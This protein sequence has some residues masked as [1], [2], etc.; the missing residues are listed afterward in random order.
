MSRRDLSLSLLTLVV[1]AALVLGA[2]AV[3]CAR[4]EE[5]QVTLEVREARLEDALQLLFRG[6]DSSY[7]LAPGNY[8]TVTA[9]LRDLPFERALTAILEPRGL[10]YRRE[11]RVYH[12]QPR[13]AEAAAPDPAPQ[14]TR[15]APAGPDQKYYWIGEGGRYQL[16]AL[17]S[18]Q[19]ASW[20]GGREIFMSPVPVAVDTPSI[21]GAT[22]GRAS[23]ASAVPSLGTGVGFGSVPGTGISS[24]VGGFASGLGATGGLSSGS[25]TGRLS[26]GRSGGV[27]HP[28]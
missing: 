26:F 22:V 8:G 24:G 1:G 23:G 11:E 2:A 7:T 27:A 28:Q 9:C 18:R 14:Q 20:F 10:T 4:A 17:D 16:Q 5:P 3:A 25:A 12:I 21:G 19:V 15:A 13:P 6:S